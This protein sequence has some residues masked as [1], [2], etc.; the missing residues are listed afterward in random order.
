MYYESLNQETKKIWNKCAFLHNDFYLAG[1]TALAFQI[2]HRI[3]VDLDFFS[4]NP[5]K[6]T[7]LAKIENELGNASVLV[8]TKNE[9]T[10]LL[11]G[12]KLLFIHYPFILKEK[13]VDTNMVPLASI[14]DIA[15]MKAYAMGRRRSFKDYIDLYYIVSKNI[16]TLG[17]IISDAKE[18]Y[19]E[20]FND[21]LFCEQLISPE[22]L[23][24]EEIIW[25]FPKQSKSNIQSFFNGKVKEFLKK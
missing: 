17:V 22:D 7:L 13:T 4:D 14:L 24:D 2:G 9:L 6:K 19:K 25:L 3:S 1:G 20:G 11:S 21:R 5:I 18:K 10:V 16:T 23:D 8:N 12:V 15:S